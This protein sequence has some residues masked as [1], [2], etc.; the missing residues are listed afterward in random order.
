LEL[1]WLLVVLNIMLN[2][3]D[4]TSRQGGAATVPNTAATMQEHL[5]ITQLLSRLSHFKALAAERELAN[6]AIAPL[7]RQLPADE[8]SRRAEAG[9]L[10]VNGVALMPY[11]VSGDGI[12]NAST[13]TLNVVC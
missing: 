9:L 12:R 1:V 8:A 3:D 11:C 2:G 13:G 6:A 10:H 4:G 5:P 7:V